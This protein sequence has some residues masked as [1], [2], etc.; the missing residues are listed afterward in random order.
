MP[1]EK[2]HKRLGGKAKGSQHK[3]TKELKDMIRNALDKVGGI[4]YLM[5]QAKDNP[6]A[7][8]TLIG[9]TLPLDVNAK[10]DMAIKV[11]IVRFGGT[12]NTP[13]GK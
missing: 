1:F 7:F 11:E 12:D 9:K 5:K 8:M 4:K 10:G 6:T 13:S 3:H 2:G